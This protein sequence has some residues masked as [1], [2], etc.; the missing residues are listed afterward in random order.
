MSF[1][2]EWYGDGGPVR[3]VWSGV[4]GGISLARLLALVDQIPRQISN[5][6]LAELEWIRHG[7][8]G[9]AVKRYK[10][11]LPGWCDAGSKHW[12]LAEVQPPLP[13]CDPGPFPV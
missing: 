13:F 8:A 1:E 4:R 9:N 11:S 6:D 12:G 2:I 3:T 7:T 5:H 10:F